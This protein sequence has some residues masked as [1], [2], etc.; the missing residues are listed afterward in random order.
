[1]ST[2]TSHTI[3]PVCMY[4]CIDVRLYV[5]KYVSACVCISIYMYMNVCMYLYMCTRTRACIF[6]YIYVRY[7]LMIL[8]KIPREVTYL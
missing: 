2:C 1:M 6:V 4:E 8:N 5:C 7:M 3:M